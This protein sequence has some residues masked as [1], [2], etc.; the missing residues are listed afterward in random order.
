MSVDKNKIQN[1]VEFAKTLDGYEKGEGQIFLDRLFKA[2]GHEGA[3]EAGAK[4]ED[5]VKIDESTKFSDLLWAGKVLIEMKSRGE[6]LENHW[7]QAKIYWDES[8]DK[9]TKYVI[10]CN[11]DEFW[12]FDWNLQ[13]EPLDKINLI[14]LDSKWLSLAFLFPNEDI[15][16]KFQ[17]N[18]VEL[19]QGA[20][21][22][23]VSF[24][25][26]LIARKLTT[27]EIA[28]RYTLQCLIALFAEDTELF[29]KPCFFEEL[30]NECI[31][32]H[33]SS[34]DL[35]QMLFTQMNSPDAASGGRFKGVNY[36]N[37]GLFKEIY[38]LELNEY[39]LKILKNLSEDYDWSKV[40]PSI[41]GAI[42][43]DSMGKEERHASGA[44]FTY[45]SDIMRI[46]EPTII[47]PFREKINS[48]KT[49]KELENIRQE[50]GDYKVLDP[51]CGSGN[52]LYI[53]FREL[54]HLEIELLQKMIK[55]FP[56]FIKK[57]S[58]V[59][60]I[61]GGNFYGID[62]NHF[63]IELA[64]VTMSMAK[65]LFADEFNLFKSQQIKQQIG[66]DLDVPLPF[67][68]LDDNIV[69]DDALFCEWPNVDTIIGNPPFI[70]K[71]DMIPELGIEYV[72]KVR[73]TYLEIPG[74]ADFCVY[75]F[76]KAHEHLKTG[77][78]AGLVGTNTISQNY[79]RIGGLD[80][81]VANN[82][83]I[84][85]AISS[86]PWQGEANV[87]VA[88][89]NWIKGQCTTIPKRLFRQEGNK[90]DSTWESW[91]LDY[92]PSSLTHE[93][94]VTQS[95]SLAANKAKGSCY[96]GQTHGHEGFLLS[97][98]VA[99][100]LIKKEPNLKDV[101][102]P[103]LIAEDL[104]GRKDSLPQRYSL[105]FTNRN[106]Y[107]AQNYKSAF[108]I[109]EK[110]VLPTRKQAAEKQQQQNDEVLKNNPRCKTNRHHI[111]F[112]KTWWQFSYSRPEMLSEI[113]RIDRYISCG[114][115]TKRPIFEFI[116]KKIRPNAALMV[117]PF[118]DDY[119]FGILS[120]IY[121][122]EWF[123]AKCS[124]LKGDWRYTSNTVF[125]S[126]VWPQ[127]GIPFVE[128]QAE[129]FLL[130]QK[131]IKNI[132]IKISKLARE[133][134]K[135]RNEIKAENNLSLREIYRS[136]D[137]P[138]NNPLR[139]IQCKLDDA[140]KEAYFFGCPKEFQS[141]NIREFLLELNEI[142][143]KAEH[144]GK[145]IQK[146]GLPDDFLQD[147]EFFSLDCVEPIEI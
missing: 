86:M 36:F 43:E 44:H 46:V 97:P 68:N 142:C 105:D 144:Q 136:L 120:S 107:E 54:K 104:I 119:S 2:F 62:K 125:D 85:E 28:Q 98:K 92:I 90:P 14:E 55:D 63:A 116:S 22:K 56:S 58:L 94:D 80:Y 141:K 87:Y 101:I 79:S 27:P 83:C 70:S 137:L 128:N 103:Y 9:R 93:I 135:M 61:K 132:M 34:Y 25:N 7:R 42:F 5:R 30:I 72:D 91:E 59:S 127:W 3:I 41:F 35:F 122:W 13:K 16:P 133:L 32:N 47:K 99:S 1:F 123:K 145:L 49:L 39:E 121:H 6:N 15:K 11:F 117:F 109:I 21:D 60:V 131:K 96:Q 138:G 48:A 113:S 20:A 76:K 139:E 45:E 110:K 118:D 100:E 51:A 129:Y 112:Y 95:K 126:F 130:S 50:M 102:Y 69:C 10:V 4:F 78:R 29:P 67:D 89:V 18:L 8:Y 77:Q 66:F 57:D 88:I 40:Q 17:N 143:F 74:H 31:G 111:N 124:T 114:Q 73:N 75:W 134:R 106:I 71:N 82:G 38:P 24:Y 140:V 115:V 26:S 53:S 12:V 23:L 19:T 146:P 64:K 33:Q 81:I 52:F 37:G 108:E 147:K 84:Y 65:K